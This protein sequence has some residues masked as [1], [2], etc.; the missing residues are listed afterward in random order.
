MI[1]NDTESGKPKYSD[2]SLCLRQFSQAPN[3]EAGKYTHDI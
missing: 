1:S 3:K 2:K